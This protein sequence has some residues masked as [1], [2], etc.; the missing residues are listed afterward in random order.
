MLPVHQP[1]ISWTFIFLMWCFSRG[2][3]C[4]ERNGLV[5]FYNITCDLVVYHLFEIR[6]ELSF[7]VANKNY[8]TYTD[9]N[10]WFFSIVIAIHKYAIIVISLQHCYFF[11]GM[12][13]LLSVLEKFFYFSAWVYLLN[14][15][16]NFIE[17]MVT[18]AIQISSLFSDQSLL[19]SFFICFSVHDDDIT[20]S[21]VA[22][23]AL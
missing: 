1:M 5:P 2:F 10:T 21:R 4:K 7:V 18:W 16:I 3:Y 13:R 6:W 11:E 9:S 23:L 15:P 19:A 22:S 17:L 12:K 20:F 8:L 14:R